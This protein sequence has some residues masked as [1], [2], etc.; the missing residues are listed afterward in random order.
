MRASMKLDDDPEIINKPDNSEGEDEG[1]ESH[2]EPDSDSES[3][4]SSDEDEENATKRTRQK[5]EKII[6]DLRACAGS[7]EIEVG[8]Y[9]LN[10]PTQLSKFLKAHE[11]YISK[12]CTKDENLMHLIAD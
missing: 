12:K 2:T 7:K 1:H 5:L 4:S 11:G 9:D 8:N 10:E 6:T 3:G